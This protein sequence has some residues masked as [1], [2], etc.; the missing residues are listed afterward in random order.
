MNELAVQCLTWIRTATNSLFCLCFRFL[1][2]E[3][4]STSRTPVDDFP[5]RRAEIAVQL[6]QSCKKHFVGCD[7]ILSD[8]FSVAFC[9]QNCDYDEWLNGFSVEFF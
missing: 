2:N 7:N 9:A 8:E 3:I 1:N 5:H 6:T 4:H